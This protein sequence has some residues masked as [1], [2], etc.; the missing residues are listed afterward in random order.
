MVNNT[1]ENHDKILM[2]N[3]SQVDSFPSRILHL[4]AEGSG[5]V[6]FEIVKCKF[7]EAQKF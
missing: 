5:E 7:P 1:C 3:I 2:A 4:L 6:N